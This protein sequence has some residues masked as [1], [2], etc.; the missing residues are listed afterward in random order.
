MPIEDKKEIRFYIPTSL[1]NKIYL[2][3]LD[4]ITLRP[5]YGL[6]SRIGTHL[7]EKWLEEIH[8]GNTLT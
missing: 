3:T 8:E 1:Y 7:L 2:L 4:P 6:V 5:K